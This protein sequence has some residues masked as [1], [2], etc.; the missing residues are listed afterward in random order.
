MLDLERECASAAHW[1]EPQ[2]EQAFQRREDA[3]QRLVLAAE[4]TPESVSKTGAERISEA[5][6]ILLGFL[7]ALHLPP[8]WELE[9]IVIAPAVRRNGLATRLLEA[10]V[11]HAQRTNSESVFLEVR[12]SNVAARTL[13]QTVGFKQTGSRKAYYASPNEDAILYRLPLRT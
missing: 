3:P 9:N 4:A 11:T 13:Y 7:V 2:Y 10:L 8:E 12:E 5:G 6:A 1:T